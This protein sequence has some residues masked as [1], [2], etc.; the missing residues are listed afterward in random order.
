MCVFVCD[1]VYV[2]VIC[3]F[4]CLCVSLCVCVSVCACSGD[5][6]VYS[7]EKAGQEFS[8]RAFYYFPFNSDLGL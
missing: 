7:V 2:S 8:Q 3:V 4:V 5:E 1:Y 6:G